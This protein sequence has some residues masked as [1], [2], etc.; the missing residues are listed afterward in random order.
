MVET[1]S[2]FRF[3]LLVPL[4]FVLS[5][6]SSLSWMKFWGDEEEEEGPTELYSIEEKRELVREWSSSLG[7]DFLYGRLIPAVY[8]EKV[9][10]LNSSGYLIAIDLNSGKKVWSKDTEEII[11]TGLDANYKTISYSTFDGQLVAL[12]HKDGKELWRTEISSESLSPPINTGNH[13]ILQTV[14]GRVSGFNAKNGE[15]DWFYQAVLP[16]LTLRGTSWPLLEEGFIFTG[17][18]N[19]KVAMIYPD[20]GAVRLELPITLNEGKSELERIVDVDGRSLIA[21]DLLIAASYQGNIIAI[22]LRD[23][24]PA[25]QEEVSTVKDLTSNGNRVVVVDSKSI[26]KAFGLAT[27]ALIWDQEDLQLRELTSPVSISNLIVVGDLEGYVHLLNAQ[28]GNFEGREKVSRNPIKEIV[29]KG[30]YLLI[31]DSAGRV[32]KFSLK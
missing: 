19:G 10:F 23:G 5:S 20:S 26:L 13:I 1:L 2:K 9:Y 25:W 4:I 3:P 28:T 11:S 22:N 18:A 8:D 29:S 7:N 12:S 32:Q 14:D 16:S 27:G 24:R 15:R 30:S 6:C 31:S 17:F 21:N